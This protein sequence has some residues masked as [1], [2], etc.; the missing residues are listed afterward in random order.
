MKT[1]VLL[2]ALVAGLLASGSAG[3]DEDSWVRVSPEGSTCSAS[4][5]AKPTVFEANSPSPF[6]PIKMTGSLCVADGDVQ[7]MMFSLTLPRAIRQQGVADDF[8]LTGFRDGFLQSFRAELVRERKT[9]LKQRPGRE[10]E[11][12]T[13][14]G[15]QVLRLRLYL[16]QDQVF[17]VGLLAPASANH[18]PTA[19][20][21][22]DSFRLER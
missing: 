11:A 18:S 10:V 9:A 2:G 8:I 4:M 20:K 13:A 14:D 3:A 7:C 17:G 22:L 12:K 1:L 21:F 19:A 15:Q 16:V 6:G 5:P